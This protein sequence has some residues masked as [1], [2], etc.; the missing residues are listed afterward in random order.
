MFSLVIWAKKQNKNVR[1]FRIPT[2]LLEISTYIVR[3]TLVAGEI[4]DTFF[5]V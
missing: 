1:L 4:Q 5:H 3:L 2:Y